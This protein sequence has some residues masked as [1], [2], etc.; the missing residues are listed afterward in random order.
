MPTFL[1]DLDPRL[2]Y[3]IIIVSAIIV[4]LANT[5]AE[6]K[7]RAALKNR[8]GP[9]FL[10]KSGAQPLPGSINVLASFGERTA[11]KQSLDEIIMTPTIGVRGIATVLTLVFIWAL[12]SG[13]F[14]EMLPKGTVLKWV[15]GGSAVLALLNTFLFEA[16]ISNRGL[17][18][19][20]FALWR[21]EYLWHDFIAI[22]DDNHYLYF[23]HFSKGG[24]VNIPKHLV[25]MPGFLQFI[26]VILE[27]NETAHAG[28]A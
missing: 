22:K 14:D 16:R 24:K 23:L 8:I 25:G 19:T 4:W 3:A 17:V 15:L 28:T 7:R 20:K 21:R 10:A 12:W 26:G 5:A 2:Y 6:R 27:Q 11:P 9:S 18:V 1:S 13:T